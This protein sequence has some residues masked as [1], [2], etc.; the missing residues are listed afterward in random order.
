MMKARRQ[1]PDTKQYKSGA[2]VFDTRMPF[3]AHV[4]VRVLQ[5]RLPGAFVSVSRFAL[6]TRVLRVGASGTTGRLSPSVPI[7]VNSVL[8][9][10]CALRNA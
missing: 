1:N 3:C 9:S 5:P 6:H 7:G 4:H 10:A 2:S 8:Y